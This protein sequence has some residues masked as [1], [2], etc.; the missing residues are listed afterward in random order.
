MKAEDLKN[1]LLGGL[2]QGLSNSDPDLAVDYV[3]E[4]IDSAIGLDTGSCTL[5]FL[6]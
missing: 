3:K 1:H 6:P 2:V 4:V 5:L